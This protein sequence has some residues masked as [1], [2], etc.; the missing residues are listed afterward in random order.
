[1][2]I[3]NGIPGLVYNWYQ[4]SWENEMEYLCSIQMF[5]DNGKLLTSAQKP[6]KSADD[7]CETADIDFITNG[8]I[9]DF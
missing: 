1:M 8:K 2:I 3:G 5:L 6:S 9:L 7:L 4:N